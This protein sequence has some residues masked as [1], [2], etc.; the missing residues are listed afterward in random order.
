[1]A[2][3][4][5]ENQAARPVGVAFARPVLAEVRPGDL[6]DEL[7]ESRRRWGSGHEVAPQKRKGVLEKECTRK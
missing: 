1:M 5:K 6:A 4:V 7:E 2:F 3:V